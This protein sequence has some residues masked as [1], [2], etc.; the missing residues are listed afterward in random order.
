MA[1]RPDLNGL[2][3]QQYGDPNVYLIDEGVRRWIPSAAVMA[4]LFTLG[5]D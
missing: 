3:V 2:R 1:P 4:Q 5:A